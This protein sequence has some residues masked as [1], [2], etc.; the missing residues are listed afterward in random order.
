M[1]PIL[2]LIPLGL[3]GGTF[4]PIHF[5]HLRLALELSQALNIER[6]KFIPGG[7]PPHRND[8]LA[9]AAHRVAMVQLAIAD[10]KRFECDTREVERSTLSY[11]V[12][13]LKEMRQ[14]FGDEFCFCFFLGSDAFLGL[15]TWHEWKKLFE[16]THIIIGQR[17]G[18][19]DIAAAQLPPALAT[20]FSQR[21]QPNLDF[22][23][24]RQAGCI[25]VVDTTLL[26]ISATRI[27]TA[28]QAN[29]SPRYLLPDPLL[30]YIARHNLYKETADAT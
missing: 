2:S 16:L 5:G 10:N 29:T 26:N 13:T 9:A 18:F 6:V 28:V 30:E 17:P 27:R 7:R 1:A 14:E 25:Y 3:F 21:L 4:N 12:E 22:I 24:T 23:K 19:H 11:S 15:S 20:E 8:P